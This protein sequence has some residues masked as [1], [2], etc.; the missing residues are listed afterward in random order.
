[1]FIVCSSPPASHYAKGI[2]GYSLRKSLIPHRGR[3]GGVPVSTTA[4]SSGNIVTPNFF[5]GGTAT[6]LP[7]V[8]RKF[9]LVFF[10]G[11]VVGGPP[12]RG[13]KSATYKRQLWCDACS[14]SGCEPGK[15]Q[16]KVVPASGG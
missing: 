3:G 7:C 14:P 13:Q 9:R 4:G 2:E 16:P 15:P 8:Q 1:M 5:W 11:Y 6:F 12:Y 10:A